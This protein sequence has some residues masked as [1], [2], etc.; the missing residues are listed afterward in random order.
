MIELRDGGGSRTLD[1][2][3]LRAYG[4]EWYKKRGIDPT[5]VKL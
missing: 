1:W 5:G 2:K 3:D 4:I